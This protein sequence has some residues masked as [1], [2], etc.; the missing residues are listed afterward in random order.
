MGIFACNPGHFKSE[1]QRK[2]E[3]NKEP[4]Y[5]IDRNKKSPKRVDLF[6]VL[7]LAL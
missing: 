5:I 7:F 6:I 2:L 4:C 1:P 3:N